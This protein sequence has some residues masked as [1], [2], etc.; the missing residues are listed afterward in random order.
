MHQQGEGWRH[1]TGTSSN[2]N[3]VSFQ[4]DSISTIIF[5]YL[6]SSSSCSATP[7]RS[8]QQVWRISWKH[9]LK[10]NPTLL[11]QF[12]TLSSSDS[13][14]CV[15]KNGKPCEY[16]AIFPFYTNVF[17]FRRD[18]ANMFLHF[19]NHWNLDTPSKQKQNM[20]GED[21][22]EYRVVQRMK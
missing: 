21:F 16:L 3:Q 12:P 5:R 1:K 4:L 11:R 13:N 17:I 9:L 8:Q 7:W 15:P 19:T 6:P 22:S 20:T 2:L 14:T 10:I 18:L